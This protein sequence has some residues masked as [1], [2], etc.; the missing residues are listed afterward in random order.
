MSAI[1]SDD[2]GEHNRSASNSFLPSHVVRRNL[3]SGLS[4]VCLGNHSRNLFCGALSHLKVSADLP[5]FFR[6]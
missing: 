4:A 3:C 1:K 6:P 5:A 2:I